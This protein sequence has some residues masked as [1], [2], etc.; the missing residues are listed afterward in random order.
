MHRF[1]QV[2][3]RAVS[4]PRLRRRGLRTA[5]ALALVVGALCSAPDATFRD[6]RGDTKSAAALVDEANRKVRRR[7]IPAAI[8]LLEEAITS[9]PSNVDAHIRFQDLT[10]DGASAAAIQARYAAAAKDKP[11]DAVAQFL[12]ERLLAPEQAVDAFEKLALRIKDSPWPRAGKA[13]ALEDLGKFADAAASHADAI[14]RAGDMAPRFLAYRAFGYERAEQWLL[15]VDAW[16]A[17]VAASPKDLAAHLGLAEAL[18]RAGR[19]DESLAALDAGAK[20]GATEP[21]LAYRRGLVHS[22]LGHW[23]KAVEAFDAALALDAGMLEALCAACDASVR[24]AQAKAAADKRQVDEKDFEKALAY[25]DR[26]VAASP[27]SPHPHFVLAA[28]HESAADAGKDGLD[29]VHLDAAL[30]HYDA[31]LD[32]LPFPGPE[33]VRALTAKAYVQIEKLDFA[34]AVD[35][36]QK[37]ID[38]DKN[39]VA[40]YGHAGFALA[41]VQKQQDA[42]NKFYK[43]G[44]R[45]D[46]QCARLLHDMGVALWEMKKVVDAKKPLEDAARLEPKTGRYRLTLGEMYY[47]LKRYKEAVA[48]LGAATDLLPRD[49]QAWLSYGRACYGNKDWAEC[50]RAYEKHVE[51][52]ADAVTPYLYLAVVYA[53]ELKDKEKARKA[54]TKFKEKGG[55]DANLDDWMDQILA[56]TAPD[57]P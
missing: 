53:E 12:A 10:R 55:T 44:L 40:A 22:D 54:V 32:R 41:A 3:P 5:L 29:A 52:N 35:T 38:I 37:A 1:A 36:A 42:I 56:D 33:R 48:E 34:A 28:A 19:S 57:K 16:N 11:D 51:L 50:A 13:R 27:D 18:R 17:V 25:G 20:V 15:A 4:V 31:A 45:V 49:A 39:C 47:E 14:A 46:P 30:K 26:A 24:L 6:A 7:E 9:D 23:D 21:E 8:A 43:P 2:V